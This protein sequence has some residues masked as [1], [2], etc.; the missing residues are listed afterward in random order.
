ME[1]ISAEAFDAASKMLTRISEL[2]EEAKRTY[3]LARK[4][5]LLDE[6]K[7]IERDRYRLLGVA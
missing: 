5:E 2:R 6:A 1:T 4:L 7:L 3:P